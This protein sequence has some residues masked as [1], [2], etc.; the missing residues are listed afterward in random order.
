MMKVR[1]RANT[2]CIV[3]MDIKGFVKLDIT[4]FF[5]ICQKVSEYEQEMPQSHN[6]DQPIVP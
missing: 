2:D 3:L 4:V 6:T 5:R 1:K